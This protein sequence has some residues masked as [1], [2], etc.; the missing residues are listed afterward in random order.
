[1]SEIRLRAIARVGKISR[2]MERA[3]FGQDEK[4]GLR[5]RPSNGNMHMNEE[6]LAA[7]G[8]STTTAHRYEQLAAPDAIRSRSDGGAAFRRL[9]RKVSPRSFIGF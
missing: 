4:G 7:P 5:G 2:Q 1:M 3:N 6:Q 8:I 9:N